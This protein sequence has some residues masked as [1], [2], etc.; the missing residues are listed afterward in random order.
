MQT[1]TGIGVGP[2]IAS[3]VAGPVFVTIFAAIQLYTSLPH[4][5]V[6]E[7]SEIGLFAVA[8]II[9]AM[10]GFVISIIPNALASLVLASAGIRSDFLRLPIFWVL[11][12]LVLPLLVALPVVTEN[13]KSL[14]ADSVAALMALSL[15]G[16]TC[17]AICRRTAY[18]YSESTPRALTIA[19]PAN[20]LSAARI[21]GPNDD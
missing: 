4:P 21:T 6:V 17:G 14:A 8:L 7:P 18:W 12:G 20:P 19:Q 2:I 11:V 13:L 3:I 5:I 16:A 1:R 15:T 10:F 9:A